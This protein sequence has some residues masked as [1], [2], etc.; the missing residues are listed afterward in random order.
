MV[1][2][3]PNQGSFTLALPESCD[4][5]QVIILTNNAVQVLNKDY[6]LSNHKCSISIKLNTGTYVIKA[7]GNGHSYATKL[8]INL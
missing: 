8:F 3:N 4:R 6:I 2:P 7:L 5:V 1:Y